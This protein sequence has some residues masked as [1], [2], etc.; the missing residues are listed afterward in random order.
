M[1]GG[2]TGSVKNPLTL[3]LGRYD[4]AGVL[5]LVVRRTALNTTV[6]PELGEHLATAGAELPWHGRQW[7]R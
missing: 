2:V 1:S 7:A 3:H 6:R 5:R 4:E